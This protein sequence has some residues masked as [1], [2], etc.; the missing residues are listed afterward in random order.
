[1]YLSKKDEIKTLGVREKKIA[2]LDPACPFKIKSTYATIKNQ[3]YI[4][5]SLVCIKTLK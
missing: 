1:M 3:C 5:Y 2:Y 4:L